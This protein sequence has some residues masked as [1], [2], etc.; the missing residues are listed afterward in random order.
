MSWIDRLDLLK[1]ASRHV[2][3]VVKQGL[4][5]NANS[6]LSKLATDFTGYVSEAFAGANTPS[7]YAV[8]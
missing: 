4:K 3:A 2:S 8:A 1:T 7:V 5:Y 6:K